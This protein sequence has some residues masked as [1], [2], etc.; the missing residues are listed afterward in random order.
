MPEPMSHPTRGR[1]SDRRRSRLNVGIS[2]SVSRHANIWA[3]G[4]NQ[5]IAFLVQSLQA[6]PF[7]NTV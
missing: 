3:N 4:I 6:I 2:I 5:N 1:A 7:V